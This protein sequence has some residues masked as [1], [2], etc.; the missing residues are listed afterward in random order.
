VNARATELKK[1]LRA[2]FCQFGTVLDVVL[3][4]AYKLRGQAWV[5]FS[6]AE[7][8]AEAKAMMEGFPL[9]EKPMVR[10]QRRSTWRVPAAHC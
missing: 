10:V 8:A 2:V 7:E 1:C 6:T 4:K 3:C 5:V 9:Y